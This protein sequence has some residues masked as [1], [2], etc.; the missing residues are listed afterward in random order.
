MTG[1]HNRRKLPPLNA[2]RAFEAAARHLSFKTA[3]EELSV[4]QSAVSHQVKALE[5]HLGTTLFQRKIRKVELTRKGK[6]LYPI[7]RN[8]LDS[9]WD[10]TQLILEESGVSVLNLHVYSTFTIRWLL[11]RLP[12]FQESHPNVQVRLHTSQADVNFSRD[13]IDAAIMV[14]QPTDSEL[15]YDYLFDCEL[16][17]VCSPSFLEKYGPINTPEDLADHP[18]LQVYP[19]S[20]DWLVWLEGNEVHG[21]SPNSGLQLESYDV[22]LSSAT[23]GIGV[24]LAQ[25]PYLSDEIEK[26]EL[27]E[28]FPTLRL[29][30]INRWYLACRREKR[31]AQKLEALYSWLKS[32]IHSDPNL[33]QSAP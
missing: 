8:A 18:I 28:I 21:V 20:G 32:E 17:P 14:G 2:L 15:H 11:P 12:R 6:L 24:A 25:Q 10:G 1:F 16:F 27:I 30:N 13:D 5:N 23:Q 19:S 9:I 3:A 7:L 22:A 29:R 26:G 4:S 31:D 33:I